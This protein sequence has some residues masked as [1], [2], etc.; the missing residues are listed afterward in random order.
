MT[1]YIIHSCIQRMWYVENYLV[2]SMLEQGIEKSIIDI[3]CDQLGLGC[4]ESCMQIFKTVIGYNDA[5]WH[6]QDDVIICRDFK[7]LTEQ[8]DEGIVCGF[9]YEKDYV[10]NVGYVKPSSMWWSFPCIRIPNKLAFQCGKWYYESVK[11]SRKYSEWVRS[12]KFDDAVFKEFLELYY[13][14][15]KVLN[16]TP[17]LVDHIDFLIGG[18]VVNKL[19]QEQQ[20]RSAYFE[21]LDLVDKLAKE[22]NN[23]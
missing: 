23:R 16:L 9:C 17:N 11:Y 6:M 2:P 5:A 18:T 21:D 14:D 10:N 19:R 15:E 13:P 4:L 8:Y 1:K 3:R 7:K 22:L 12:R 20:T